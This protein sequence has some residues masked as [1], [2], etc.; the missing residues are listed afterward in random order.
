M[1]ERPPE[2]ATTQAL[3]EHV[4]VHGYQEICRRLALEGQ[5][6]DLMVLLFCQWRH[7]HRG[8]DRSGHR[9]FAQ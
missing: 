8:I 1:I 2:L 4:Y 6:V 7:D 9:C 3:G 5:S